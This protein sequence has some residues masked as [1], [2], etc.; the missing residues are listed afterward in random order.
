MWALRNWCR[1]GGNGRWRWVSSATRR[2]SIRR[3]RLDPATGEARTVTWDDGR[4]LPPNE[5][6]RLKRAPALPRLPKTGHARRREPLNLA[7]RET[8]TVPVPEVGVLEAAGRAVAHIEERKTIVSESEIRT[9]ALGHAP[10]RYRLAEI[11][12]AIGRLVSDGELV[13]TQRRGTDRAFVTD[14]AIRAERRILAWQR[15]G[16]GKGTVLALPDVVEAR[17][18]ETTLTRGQQAAVRQILLSH[19]LTIG[20]QGHAGT[21]KTTMLREVAGLLGS[22][23]VLGLAP[24]AAATDV[25]R[26][27]AGIEARTL[28]WFLVR[29]G[30]LSS[31]ERL[32]QARAERAGTVLTVDEASMIGTVQME[33]LLRIARDL[34]VARVVL[35]GDTAQLRSVDA[36]QP[37]RLLQRKGMAT[38]HMDEVMRQKDPVLKD[39]VAR[40]REGEPAAAF[41]GLTGRITEHRRDDLGRQAGRRW[42][43]LEPEDRERCIVLA[44]THAIRRDINDTVREALSEEGVLHGRTLVVERLVDRRLTRE[45]ASDIRS[46]REGDHIVFHRDAYGCSVDDVCVVTAIDDGWI[47][48]DHED[49]I[50]R[51]FRPSGNAAR[52]LGVYDTASI[53]IRAGDRI[54]WTRNRKAP[55]ARYG[56]EPAPA[57]IN[58]EEAHV[59]EIGSRRVRLRTARGREFSLPRE[60]AQLRHLDHAYSS[61][62]HGAQG[63][64][65]ALVIAVLDAG[66]MADQDMFY[67]EVSR[68]SEG[69]SLLTDDREALLEQLEQRPSRLEGAL[70]AIAE[71][72]EPVAVDPDE[73]ARLV[74]DW[75]ALERRGKEADTHP[76][77]SPGYAGIMARVSALSAIEDLPASLR[78]FTEQL[79]REHDR[80]HA[81]EREVQG[82]IER[83][84][85]HWR[86]WPELRWAA[87]SLGCAPEELPAWSPWRDTGRELLE[88]GGRLLDDDGAAG[89]RLGAVPERR[90]GLETAL[91]DLRRTRL[92]DDAFRF[93]RIWR[94][95]RL[96]A[97]QG[98]T[99]ECHLEGYTELARMGE[100]LLEVEGLEEE[101][102]RTVEEW[103]ALHRRQTASAGAIHRLRERA[104]LTLRLRSPTMVASVM[105]NGLDPD[106]PDVIAWRKGAD[107][108]LVDMREMLSPGS[109]HAPYLSVMEDERTN[110][111]NLERSIRQVG[112]DVDIL[113]FRWRARTVTEQARASGRLPL[114]MP[115]YPGLMS[116]VRD[117]SAREGLS[118]DHVKTLAA[119]S[120][121]DRRWLQDRER[122]RIFSERL[123]A[124]RDR[125]PRPAVTPP[126]EWPAGASRQAWR[127]EARALLDEHRVLADGIPKPEL[128]AHLAANGLKPAAFETIA[129]AIAGWLA[130]DEAM[131]ECAVWERRAADVLGG[132][133]R[134]PTDPYPDGWS[135]KAE[136]LVADGRAMPDRW[137]ARG[138]PSGFLEEIRSVIDARVRQIEAALLEDAC[139]SFHRH[140]RAVENEARAKAIHPFDTS[141][142]DALMARLRALELRDDLP[143]DTAKEVAAWRKNDRIWRHNRERTRVFA[144][145]L[146]ALREQ[147]PDPEEIADARRTGKSRQAWR[148]EAQALLDE[149]RGL[150]KDIPEGRWAAHLAA[151]A[152]DPADIAAI[153]DAIPGWLTTDDALS[154]H[155]AWEQRV[156]DALDE[157]D[158][159]P[160]LTSAE[161][162]PA[163][164]PA[165]GWRK[166]AA[167]LIAEGQ[168]MHDAWKDRDVST[169]GQA[170]AR[171]LIRDWIRKIEFALVR[172]KCAAFDRRARSVEAEVRTKG[173]HPLDAQDYDAL[174]THVDAL[175][176]RTGVP[177]D[178]AKAVAT[179][180]KNDSQWDLD[181]KNVGNFADRALKLQ[182]DREPPPG[183]T[184]PGI[185]PGMWRIDAGTVLDRLRDLEKTLSERDRNAHLLAHGVDPSTVAGIIE[186]IPAW[187]AEAER[188]NHLAGVEMAKTT[189][190]A[191]DPSAL[192]TIPWDGRNRFFRATGSSGHPMESTTT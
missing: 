93:T 117:L 130:T 135:E 57:L 187:I 23:P 182:R 53:E 110:I 178:T 14:R 64:T 124:L 148:K 52:N 65:S 185:S 9:L 189:L 120:E 104:L 150:M 73:A 160:G 20:V 151:H 39:V 90:H 69:F 34:Q 49:G 46:Y 32:E 101:Q 103:H 84:Q 113:T 76:Y 175:V 134:L 191:A 132:G 167:A 40:A 22:R 6:R 131:S 107:A 89:R 29:Y 18:R 105:K 157:A 137:K 3:S 80:Q 24:S 184:K 174:M 173:V 70:E 115:G 95:L 82:L 138:V 190:R 92:R 164:P 60:D 87:S 147:R 145:R 139:A 172:D 186:A 79:L 58:G 142:Y 181:R 112:L 96:Q 126:D 28:Q 114:D 109:V 146:T 136:A 125:Q 16:R 102:R 2:R 98:S 143:Q 170:V 59:L 7:T 163:G 81:K 13:E 27:E 169:L 68:A 176:G 159:H 168:A 75:K 56:R 162:T 66:G 119:W 144:E 55:P 48:L 188:Q 21:G 31:P 91:D 83:I 67:V 78:A 108:C 94:A 122:T 42:L 180:R 61:T 8:W 33:T 38:A 152:L 111:A 123:K 155:A 97:E 192:E 17:L 15:E 106:A 30:E 19:D 177:A 11:D 183:E 54:R 4:G 25:L 74:E 77:H 129:G 99:P 161:R 140:V 100:A 121:D 128:A 72:L 50:E 36:G 156:L 5:I 127:K 149:H 10:G 118:E 133:E 44:P 63:R 179:W 171:T 45:R 37:F 88:E 85:D 165:G 86:R 71:D 43:A 158:R 62:V 51:R 154:Q 35:T 166:D 26:R 41:A 47:V 116:S 1:N 12:A 141:P 153:V